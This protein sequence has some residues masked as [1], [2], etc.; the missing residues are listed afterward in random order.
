MKFTLEIKIQARGLASGSASA[1]IVPAAI[2]PSTQELSLLA[3]QVTAQTISTL[4]GIAAILVRKP[5]DQQKS[6]CLVTT[7]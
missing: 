4:V 7:P 3:N 2:H 5:R 6:T 1:G